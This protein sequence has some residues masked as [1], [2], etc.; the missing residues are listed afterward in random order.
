MSA[1]LGHIYVAQS[2][3][4]E[5]MYKIGCCTIPPLERI[6]QLS[7]STSAPLPFNLVYSRAV[8]QPF[9]VE[10]ALHRTF[11]AY[12]VNDAREFFQVPLR[13]IIE[14]IEKY[15]AAGQPGAPEEEYPFAALFASFA[16]DGEARD[17][18]ADEQAQCR[19]LERKLA[20]K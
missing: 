12:R 8:C 10:A 16:D 2:P 1:L 7:A 14:E 18:T 20:R 5:G 11:D 13:H 15:P 3:A 4:L 17:L 6:R 9:Q 19:V